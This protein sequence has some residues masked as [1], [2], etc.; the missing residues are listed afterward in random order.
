MRYPSGKDEKSS[1][2]E[3]RDPL[4]LRLRFSAGA[5][6]TDAPRLLKEYVEVREIFGD[7]LR[8]HGLLQEELSAH[9]VSLFKHGAA[10]TMRDLTG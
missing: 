8:D 5:A 9:L 10:R 4:A 1:K 2:I 3:V 7:D 6:G